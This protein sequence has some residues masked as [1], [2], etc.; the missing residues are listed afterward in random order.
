VSDR[1]A[2]RLAALGTEHG[3][4]E[5]AVVAL[6]VL[7]DVLAADEHAATTVRDPTEAVDRHV[8]DGLSGLTAPEIREARTL[9][10]VGTGIGVPALVLA[11]ARP[12]L[13]VVAMD[14]V[15]RKVEWVAATA[16]RMGLQ[17]VRTVHGRAEAWSAGRHRFDVVTARAVAPLGVLLEYAAPLLRPGGAAGDAVAGGSRAAPRRLGEGTA[18]A[19]GLPPE[20]RGSAPAPPVGPRGDP[21]SAASFHVK[22]AA[23][24]TV[25]RETPRGCVPVTRAVPSQAPTGAAAAVPRTATPRSH[26]P[27]GPHGLPASSPLPTRTAPWAPSTRSRTRRAASARRRRR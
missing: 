11:A 22:R 4:D 24:A 19:E 3:L 18:D 8:A 2:A 12:E 26:A 14:T 15:R 10:D 25:S 6:G 17:N 27:A 16:E 13:Q 9:V 23:L 7:L 5:P 21:R 1:V 20:A